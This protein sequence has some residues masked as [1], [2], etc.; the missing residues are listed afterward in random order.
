M[1][2]TYLILLI[3]SG[4]LII[5]SI[6]LILAKIKPNGLYGFRTKKTLS[7]EKIWYQANKFT[8]W[9]LLLAA[10][11]TGLISLLLGFSKNN[12]PEYTPLLLLLPIIVSI[13]IS[14]AYVRKLT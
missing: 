12:Y 5:L 1:N 6:P 2:Q 3:S 14:A 11:I 7:N 13:I 8:G 4:L 10:F 9:M